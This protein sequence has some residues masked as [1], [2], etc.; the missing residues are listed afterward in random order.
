MDPSLAGSIIQSVIT[1]LSIIIAAVLAVRQLRQEREIT[2]EQLSQDRQLFLEQMND[3]RLQRLRTSLSELL[4][5][6]RAIIL[7]SMH[8]PAT[9]S[10]L[11]NEFGFT[12]EQL[13]REQ[14]GLYLH[15][16]L[17]IDHYQHVYYL[18]KRGLF[19]GELW[20]IWRLSMSES[21][22]TP[23][24]QEIMRSSFR[25]AVS[26]EFKQFIEQGFPD[27]VPPNVFD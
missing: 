17:I 2:R 14:G 15:T 12:D 20:P 4:D 3:I 25:H 23:L 18:Y 21:F 5:E 16:F 9:A 27:F 24:F 10:W 8:D 11:L 6:R 1:T 19:S 13:Q 7:S 26:S 22:T